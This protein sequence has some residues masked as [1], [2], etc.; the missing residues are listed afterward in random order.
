[1]PELA[2]VMSPEQNWFFKELVAAIREELD[3]Q[4]VASSVSTDGF[5]EPAAD[6]V[7]A[8]V[9]PHEYVAL[10]GEDALP[11][12]D[13]LARTI[14]IC[15]EQP[16]TSHFD[17]NVE[18]ARRAGATYDINS[19]SV[20]LYGRAGIH[21]QHLQVGYTP[22]WDRFDRDRDRDIDVV[23][24][25]CHSP[26]R[27]RHL[28]AYGHALS[29]YSCHIQLSDNSR[30]NTG[31]ST[32]FMADEKWDLLARAKLLIN[33]HQGDEPYF[34]W[35]RALDAMHCGAVVLSEHSSGIAPLVPG[36]HLFVGHPES[37]GQ[38][39]DALLRDA[40]RLDAVR[41]QAYDFIRSSMP[42]AASAAALAGTVRAL[43]TRPVAPHRPARRPRR[44]KPRDAPAQAA[45]FDEMSVIRQ[46]IKDSRLDLLDVRRQL[47]RL[48][49]SVC[50]SN[51]R[52]AS[53]V[54]HVHETRGWRARRGATVTVLTA[55]Y[56][57]RDVIAAALD[58][59]AASTHEDFEIV[60]VDDGSS[61]GSGDVARAWMRAHEDL[62]ARL[63]RHPVN[64]GLGA[65]RNTALDFARGRYCFVLDSDNE[66][67]P[68]C[69][70]ALVATLDADPGSMF[71]YP[72]LEAVGMVDAYVATGGSPLVSMFGWEPKRLRKGNFVD[73]LALIR[74]D[75]LRELGG[76]TTDRRL[77]GWEDYDL[78]CRIAERGDRGR[79]VPQILARYRASPTSMRSITN[80]SMAGALAA[81][82]ERHPRLMAGVAPPD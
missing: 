43:V 4:G 17:R 47:A 66:V 55:L 63:V 48:E 79:Q 52:P 32:S 60:V 50:A 38:M 22:R 26:R 68:R 80:L 31:S 70:G 73:A 44:P 67:Y 15:A 77:Y 46:G 53:R 57:H 14:F 2:F 45:G 3:R 5:P 13:M 41:R 81:V 71:A 51:G 10:E 58:S 49:Q 82:I 40:E 8:L 23:F 20:H 65:A 25:G 35:L 37:L 78:W 64:R 28:G 75:L 7:C 9:P 61:D 59:L 18:L 16:G 30:P 56:N 72:I 76:Y 39:A 1:M 34:E 19:R 21:A 29:R 24:L 12:D 33:L 74:T 36:R 69:L 6:R 27:A 42:F 11:G 54:V 62:A